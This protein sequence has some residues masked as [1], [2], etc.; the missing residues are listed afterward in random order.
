MNTTPSIMVATPMY[1]GM[2]Y[3]P[4]AQ[5]LL[6]LNYVL[7]QRG[8]NWDAKF[9]FNES[10]ITRARD[11]LAAMFMLDESFTHLLFLDADIHFNGVDIVKM[12][13]ADKDIIGGCY[14]TKGIDWD[15]VVTAVHQG[16]P[17]ELLPVLGS[18]YVFHT[19]DP[20]MKGR[21][22]DTT[23][24][25]VARIG[26][27]MMLIKREV[28][29]KLKPHTPTY[30]NMNVPQLM[31]KEVHQYFALSI[32][33]DTKHLYSEDYHFCNEWRKIGGEVWAAPWAMGVHIGSY[34]FGSHIT[35]DQK[36]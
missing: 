29:E 7:N 5:S 26:T 35:V 36:S 4:F 13:E 34:H 16:V 24:V 12:I 11:D 8:W 31:N 20:T 30:I 32:D 18:N 22:G 19:L 6:N 33:P 3:G 10:L 25:E 9:I 23:P 27:G 14:P 21:P 17:T 1:G 2:C 15:Q 28:F